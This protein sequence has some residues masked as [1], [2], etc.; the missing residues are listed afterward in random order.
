MA[1]G[2]TLDGGAIDWS[3]PWFQP[4]RQRGEALLAC[5]AHGCTVAEAL[6]D[7]LAT[8]PI[9][10]ED[11]RA[12]RFVEQRCLPDGQAY[13]AFIHAE[14]AVPT[15]H[16][17]HDFFNGLIWLHW[18]ALKLRLNHWHAQALLDQ[19]GV[20]PQRGALRDALTLLDENAAFL[21]GPPA[22]LAALQR[23][24]WPQLFIALRPL[25]REA[26]LQ[27]VGHAL[28]EKLLQPRKAICAHTLLQPLD[29][30]Q[31]ADLAAKPF[32]PLPVLGIPGWADQ[33]QDADFYA[34][35]QVFRRSALRQTS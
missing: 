17:W 10:R 3:R 1:D 14:A 20:G 22:L 26:R 24:D 35:A 33:P 34:D 23:R 30:M 4:Y 15:R 21:S 27:I 28:L 19:G 9:V 5:I 6:N 11:G 2:L 16:N 31:P 12:L 25:W 32:H 18:P 29:R 8:A 7:A 13:E